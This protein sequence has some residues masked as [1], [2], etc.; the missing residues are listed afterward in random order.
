[1]TRLLSEPALRPLP[2]TGSPFD[3]ATFW[4]TYLFWVGL[5]TVTSRRKRV[6][7]QSASR[8]RGSYAFLMVM[9]WTS[10]SLEFAMPFI[11]PGAAMQ[12]A[13]MPLFFVGVAL[14]LAGLAFRFYSMSLL[15]RF[16]TYS[17]AVQ[18]GQSVIEAGPYRY[19]RH[20]SYTGALITLIGF[21]LAMGNWLGL[22]V[23]LCLM[24]I[25]YAYR[26][27]VEEAALTAALGKPYAQYMLR[28]Q[29]L[30]PFLF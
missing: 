15:G 23:L 7:E 18:S 16:F 26:I 9:L 29:R 17:V 8:D 27:S 1:M 11:A 2:Y 12:H 25:G 20:P 13:M 28:T 19:I 21:G 22:A 24:C 14:M 5:E 3:Q 6:R 10:L 4:T 30:V